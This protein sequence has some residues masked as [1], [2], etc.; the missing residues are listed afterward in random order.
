VNF[1]IQ[2][3]N[4]GRAKRLFAL[5]RA[6]YFRFALFGHLPGSVRLIRATAQLT[7]HF[8]L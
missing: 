4:I 1:L 3:Q 7:L 5:R 8:T 6:T 2:P